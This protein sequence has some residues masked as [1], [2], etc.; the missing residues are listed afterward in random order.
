[1]GPRQEMFDTNASHKKIGSMISTRDQGSKG[2][3]YEALGL[4]N[5]NSAYA[6]TRDI[7]FLRARFF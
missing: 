4:V 6:D 2:K 1:M 3:E 7:D 5:N